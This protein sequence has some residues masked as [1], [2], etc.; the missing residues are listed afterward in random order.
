MATSLS[1]AVIESDRATL[2]ALIDLH[3]YAAVNPASSKESLIAL[4]A[5]LD[6]AEE[7]TLRAR[8]ALVAARDVKVAA[9]QAFHKAILSAKA[10]VIAQYGSDAP[11]VRAIG[12]KKKSDH[13]QR[14]R[15]SG[16]TA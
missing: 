7:A 2:L 3:D 11:Q 5:A 14:R 16:L 6:Q 4:E 1:T 10:A 8:K 13:R 12:L 9:E 15:R